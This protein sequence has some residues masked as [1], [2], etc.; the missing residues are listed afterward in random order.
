MNL[1]Q[2]DRDAQAAARLVVAEGA[3]MI[4]SAALQLYKDVQTEARSVGGGFGSPVASGRFAASVRLEINGID[5]SAEPA[6]PN[7]D[8]P[9]G[10]GPRELPPRTIRNRPI[11][12][13]AAKLRGF[14]L[15]DRI[16]VSNSVPYARR[17]E[18][19]RHSWQTPDGVFDPTVRDWLRRFSGARIR[20]VA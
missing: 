18:I 9:A 19:G 4:R 17:I 16:F 11:S 20:R 1:S 13:T 2:F 5:T 3:E 8:Y 14:R 15:G 7:Y 12:A 6:D 10:S